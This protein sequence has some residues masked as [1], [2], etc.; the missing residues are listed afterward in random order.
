MCKSLISKKNQVQSV[1]VGLS[2]LTFRRVASRSE[3]S[4]QA[5]LFS[6]LLSTLTDA[7]PT[8]ILQAFFTFETKLSSGTCNTIVAITNTYLRE[9]SGA[10]LRQVLQ[11]SKLINQKT[12]ISD[13]SA[14][15][16]SMLVSLYVSM[17][18]IFL[19]LVITA[20]GSVP[21]KSAPPVQE[22]QLI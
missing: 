12:M 4:M 8:S 11:L 6:R 2:T 17:L 16:S 10:K 15:G 3:D 20:V 1:K 14:V 7:T 9:Y 21:K 13:V 18:I 19:R 5:S 22:C